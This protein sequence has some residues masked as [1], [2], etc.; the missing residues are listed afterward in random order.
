MLINVVPIWNKRLEATEQENL[1][2]SLR[3]RSRD[4]EIKNIWRQFC[5]NKNEYCWMVEP[6]MT[7]WLEPMTLEQNIGIVASWLNY[8][9]HHTESYHLKEG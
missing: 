8:Y 7:L 6:N 2:P 4:T 5:H 1:M 3:R 9:Q